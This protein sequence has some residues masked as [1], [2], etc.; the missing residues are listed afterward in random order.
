M[1]KPTLFDNEWWPLNRRVCT[2]LLANVQHT[3]DSILPE[4]SLF[5]FVGGLGQN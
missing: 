2:V 1:L 4:T 5:D 3:L